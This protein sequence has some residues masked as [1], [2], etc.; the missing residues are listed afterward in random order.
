[1]KHVKRTKD[2]KRK[3]VTESPEKRAK[4]KSATNSKAANPAIEKL[5]KTPGTPE[6]DKMPRPSST[7]DLTKAAR[8]RSATK[9]E[10]PIS[11]L[12]GISEDTD[13]DY[14]SAESAESVESELSG[15][16]SNTDIEE[17]SEANDTLIENTVEVEPTVP[18]VADPPIQ[19]D[20]N[21]VMVVRSEAF[22]QTLQEIVNKSVVTSIAEAMP[23]AIEK[24]AAAVT[25][26]KIK[27]SQNKARIDELITNGGP[28]DLQAYDN[29]LNLIETR[30]GQVVTKVDSNEGQIDTL[31]KEMD[32]FDLY[33]RASNLLFSAVCERAGENLEDRICE[34]VGVANFRV[35]RRDITDAFR[36]GKPAEGKT[37]MILVK[38]FEYKAKKDIYSARLRLKDPS[39][40]NQRVHV[41]EDLPPKL[42]KLYHDARIY[43]KDIVD[44][45]AWTLNGRIW[46]TSQLPLVKPVRI[47]TNQDLENYMKARPIQQAPE[48]L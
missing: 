7:P 13:D 4:Q 20:P 36:L 26:I 15:S 39:N 12:S 28:V 11:D 45:S 22:K 35:T 1:M 8:T 42:S 44:L 16:D 40:Q 31:T 30:L 33:K 32:N 23:K 27:V 17:N 5:T 34:I 2:A 25:D 38:F 19:V 6:L 46:I 41:N 47:I 21:L 29:K 9:D 24:I 48:D 3:H 18:G 43:A 37:R 10:V 14:R